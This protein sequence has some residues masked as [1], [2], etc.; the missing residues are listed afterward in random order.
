MSG[1]CVLDMMRAHPLTQRLPVVVLSLEPNARK[2]RRHDA[3]DADAYVSR[4]RDFRRY[5][6]VLR[7]C[8]RHWL[9]SSHRRSERHNGMETPPIQ[10]ATASFSCG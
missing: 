10:L 9:P 8:V 2:H 7:G 1:L 6:A 4:P 5:C 3:F